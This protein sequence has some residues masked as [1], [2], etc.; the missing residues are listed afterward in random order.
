MATL[1][2]C[3]GA[4]CPAEYPGRGRGCV[5]G[6]GGDASCG[7][8]RRRFS[9][10]QRGASATYLSMLRKHMSNLLRKI[11]RMTTASVR[12]TRTCRSWL[13]V[14]GAVQIVARVPSSLSPLR[15]HLA[16]C[17]LQPAFG[18]SWAS[19][20]LATRPKARQLL[21]PCRI[22]RPPRHLPAALVTPSAHPQRASTSL[23]QLG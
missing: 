13:S 12:R 8:S 18:S 6:C 5:C 23:L 11:R 22:E 17:S 2:A 7:R 19:T 4:G 10:S 3:I 21:Y 15:C 16:S 20:S 9:V 1:W 14:G